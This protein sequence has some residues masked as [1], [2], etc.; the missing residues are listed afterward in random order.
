MAGAFFVFFFGLQMRV[1]AFPNR[2]EGIDTRLLYRF[3]AVFARSHV[4]RSLELQT[5]QTFL[6]TYKPPQ[7]NITNSMTYK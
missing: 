7:K 5:L 3:T 6:Q 4:W 2:L 1:G